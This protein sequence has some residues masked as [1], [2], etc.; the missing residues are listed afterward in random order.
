MRI[1][2]SV[3]GTRLAKNREV[4]SNKSG[5]AGELAKVPTDYNLGILLEGPSPVSLL[6]PVASNGR[7]SGARVGADEIARS[8][9]AGEVGTLG[10]VLTLLAASK[11]AGVSSGCGCR[12][13]RDAFAAFKIER[14]GPAS[15][16][17]HDCTHWNLE[18]PNHVFDHNLVLTDLYSG[19]PKEHE[20]YKGYGQNQGNAQNSSPDTLSCKNAHESQNQGNDYD[21]REVS[22]GLS[23]KN[24]HVTSVA[25]NE[26]GL[27]LNDL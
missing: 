6:F 9:G 19:K 13:A 22:R 5:K 1:N 3:L 26:K 7:S 2:N 16:D 11:D 23:C 24:L 21:N 8:N 12:P 15:V 18:T 10:Q 27:C 14:K 17:S 25:V 20:S 4:Q